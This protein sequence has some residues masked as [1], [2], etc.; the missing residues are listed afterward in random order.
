MT[1]RNFG[2]PADQDRMKFLGGPTTARTKLSILIHIH[3]RRISQSCS[4]NLIFITKTL[5]TQIN[6]CQIIS[7]SPLKFMHSNRPASL[8]MMEGEPSRTNLKMVL[9]C[10]EV[11]SPTKISLRNVHT[12]E[13]W[14]S[15]SQNLENHP[16]MIKISPTPTWMLLEASTGMLVLQREISTWIIAWSSH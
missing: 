13:N 2:S 14:R 9:R 7:N 3:P 5:K 1:K 16:E 12:L 8:H 10:R 4:H 11:T 15:K 6:S